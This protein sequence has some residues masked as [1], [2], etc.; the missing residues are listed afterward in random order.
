MRLL[1]TND[2]GIAGDG[3]QALIRVLHDQHEVWVVAPSTEASGGSHSI[4]LHDALKIRRVADRQFSCRGTPAD[5]VM[6]AL[7]GL[8]P[9][10]VDLV[11]SGINHGPNLGTDILYSGTAAG[12]R[13]GSLMGVPSVAL[14]S[15][16]YRPPFDF[17][18]GAEFAAR[19]LESF[20]A[21]GTDDHFLN[22]NFPVTGTRGAET[23]I[24][25]PS[26]RIYRME[27]HTYDAPD[28]DRYCFIGGPQPEA[29]PEEGSDCMVVSQGRISISP[30]HAHPRNWATIEDDCRGVE[31]R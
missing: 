3:I 24:T 2:D 17:E 23:V 20:R 22:V 4:T 29:H 26:R 9:S 28:G 6:V 11:I 15:G 18:A 30:I 25:F 14:S 12:A 16:S 13:Q 1:L 27:L 10:P 8:V 7:L 21:L 5:C 19:N 31:F